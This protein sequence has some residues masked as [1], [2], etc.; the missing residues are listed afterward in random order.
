MGHSIL[1]P[2]YWFL[3]LSATLVR[4][5]VYLKRGT[6]HYLRNRP[7]PDGIV[8]ETLKVPSRDKGR[9]IGVD[10]YRPADAAASAKLPVIV[11]WHG[12]GYVIPSWGEDREYVVGAVK[13]LGCIVLDCDYRKGPEYPYPSG[14]DDAEDVVGWVLSQSQRFDVTKVALSGFSSGAALA[15]NTANFYGPSKIH[16]ISALYPPVDVAHPQPP[17]PVPYE[18]RSGLYL[19]PGAV[20]LFNNSYMPILATREEPRFRIRGLETSRFP[21]HIFIA[22][23]DVD[24][25][26]S[27]AKKY[28]DELVQTEKDKSITFVSVEREEHAWDKM[29]LV[30]ESVKARDD[31][32]RQMFDN[33]KTS[34][35]S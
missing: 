20:R 19:S 34:F 21:N 25:L 15:L 17:K 24:L 18:P 27:T 26:H 9:F 14:H 30:P 6:Q 5:L 23:G 13:A 16:A 7:L 10:L 12:S 29:P 1:S 28:F 4:A 8:R 35:S 11:N 31:V 22:C 32:Y 3:K 33:I 2:W